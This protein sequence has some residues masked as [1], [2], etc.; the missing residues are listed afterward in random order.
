MCFPG[1]RRSS[2]YLQSAERDRV[3]SSGP[4]ASL[5]DLCALPVAPHC[6]LLPRGP[7]YPAARG[8]AAEVPQDLGVGTGR[9]GLRVPPTPILPAALVSEVLAVHP[10]ACAK[11]RASP[12]GRA[13][14]PGALAR[15]AFC[16]CSGAAGCSGQE[17]STARLRSPASGELLRGAV[18]HHP[19]PRTLQVPHNPAV[20]SP[21]PL[22]LN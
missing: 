18:A 7:L 5:E 1:P 11:L 15:G 12:E 16:Y 22:I 20:S 4:H 13:G 2:G 21:F 8:W 3:S 14:I 9:P 19:V 17:L 10:A 6:A